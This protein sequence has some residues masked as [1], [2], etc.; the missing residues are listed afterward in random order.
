MVSAVAQLS[1]RFNCARKIAFSQ[2]Q[3]QECKRLCLPYLVMVLL[4]SII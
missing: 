3:S 4:F 2:K 1:I